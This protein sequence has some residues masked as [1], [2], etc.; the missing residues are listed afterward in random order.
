MGLLCFLYADPATPARSDGQCGA[1]AIAVRALGRKA[2]LWIARRD[3]RTVGNG[4]AQRGV[5][6]DKQAGIPLVHR[7]VPDVGHSFEST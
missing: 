3:T 2:Q 6:E 1:V 7:P 5:I 4:K